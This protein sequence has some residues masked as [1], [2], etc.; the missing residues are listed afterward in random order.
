MPCAARQAGRQAG[1]EAG[2]QAAHLTTRNQM[3]PHQKKTSR[4]NAAM[5]APTRVKGVSRTVM[6]KSRVHRWY[7][8]PAP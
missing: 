2:R 3:M 5:P 1:G 4:Y 7:P 8:R 6:K